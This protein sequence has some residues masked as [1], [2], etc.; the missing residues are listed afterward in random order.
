MAPNEMNTDAPPRRAV[1]TGIGIVAPNGH[2][3]ATFWDSLCLGTSGAGLISQFDVKGMPSVIG[4]E[5]KDFDPTRYMDAKSARRYDR[6]IRYAVAA[7]QM[8]VSDSGLKWGSLDPDR[9]AVVEGT[10]AS[11]LDSV[12]RAHV[13]L[14]DRGPAAMNPIHVINGYCGQGSSA[15]ALELGICGHSMTLCSGCASSND[16]IG[17]ALNL[18]QTDEVDVVLAGGA[19]ANVTREL[20]ASWNTLGVMTRRQSDP[21]SAMRPFDRTRD[22]FLLGE[23]GTFLIVEELSHALCRRARIYAEV[24]G[25]GRSSESHHLIEPHPEGKGAQRA[26]EKA[27]RMARV[28]AT[29]VDYINPHGSA[30]KVHDRIE[31]IA[32]KKI[33]GNHAMRVAI[34]ATK[35]ITGHLMGAAG[36]IEAAVCCLTIFHQIIPPTINLREPDEECDLDYVPLKARPYPVQVALSLNSAFGGRNSCLLMGRY[37]RDHK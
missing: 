21:A 27:L 23:G 10:T 35:P 18:I 20:W 32:I 3:L 19:D 7:A 26:I 14:L 31:T 11:G 2:D 1:V 34:S 6:S 15:V 17:Y 5:V 22:G 16:A 4:A 9:A 25:Q 28:H 24:L 30:T 29:E 12:L 36:A 33:L 13:A 8:A 37:P